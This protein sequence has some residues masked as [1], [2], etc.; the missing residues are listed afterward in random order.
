MTVL[1]SSKNKGENIWGYRVSAVQRPNLYP[2]DMM[3]SSLRMTN[4]DDN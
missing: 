4:K 3:I 2:E 1:H